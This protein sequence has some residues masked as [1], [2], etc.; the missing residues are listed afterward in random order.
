[1]EQ[2]TWA[3][4]LCKRILSIVPDNLSFELF[5]GIFSGVHFSITVD[6]RI[7]CGPLAK[8]RETWTAE[9]SYMSRC[10]SSDATFHLQN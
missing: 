6:V 5:L 7:L 1:M 10:D 4:N 9:V 8:T 3:K 2:E